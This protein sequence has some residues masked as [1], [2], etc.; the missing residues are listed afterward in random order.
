MSATEDQTPRP[1]Q[2]AP[3]PA[4]LPPVIPLQ[5]DPDRRSDVP[6]PRIR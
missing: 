5:P 1:P 4:P 6:R 2:P 3:P